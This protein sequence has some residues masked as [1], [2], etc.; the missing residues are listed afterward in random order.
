LTALVYGAETVLVVCGSRN[1]SRIRQAV[2]EQVQTARIILQ[3][4]GL[5]EDKIRFIPGSAPG[6]D[7]EK[8]PPRPCEPD[9]PLPGVSGSPAALP[10]GADQRGRIRLA[11][12]YLYDRSGTRAPA[13]PLPPGSPFGAVLVDKKACTLCL[14]CVA[15]CP[16]QALSAGGQGPQLKFREAL[17]HQCGLCQAT[18]PEGALRLLPRLLCDREAVEAR[19][20]LCE[21]APVRCV[22]CG[23][24]IAS[25]ALI[26]RIQEKLQGH[27]MYAEERQLR[28]LQMCGPCRTRDTLMSED[29]RLWKH[30]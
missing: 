29:L 18:C 1:P 27:W 11:V 17:C 8:K 26:Q 5:P 7:S 4:L 30:H 14:A 10:L 25:P 13:V 20:V 21:D 3:G 2:E 12:Q 28:R 6:P 23:Q 24:A 19:V 22:D 16:A 15:A 9:G